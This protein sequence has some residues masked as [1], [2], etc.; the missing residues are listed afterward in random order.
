[1]CIVNLTSPRATTVT[2]T[3]T[4]AKEDKAT[5]TENNKNMIYIFLSWCV[6]NVKK[7]KFRALNKK[8]IVKKRVILN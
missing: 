6:R 5:I 8:G 1:M 3:V 4:T 2:I 7:Q